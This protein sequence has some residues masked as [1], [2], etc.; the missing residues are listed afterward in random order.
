MQEEKEQSQPLPTYNA[1][2][3]KKFDTETVSENHTAADV[4]FKPRVKKAVTKEVKKAAEQK[5]DIQ[6]IQKAQL[7]DYVKHRLIRG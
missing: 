7:L 5:V 1:M 3:A 6:A 2:K 4:R